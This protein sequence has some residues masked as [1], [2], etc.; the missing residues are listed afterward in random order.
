LG[1]VDRIQR[2]GP[3][4]AGT[5]NVTKSTQDSQY[6][7][8]RRVCG[9]RLVA[10]LIAV[11]AAGGCDRSESP[12]PRVVPIPKNIETLR[13]ELVELIQKHA[14]KV[15]SGMDDAIAIATLGLVYEANGLW[16]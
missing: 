10:L 15:R 1:E 8:G 2:Q 4:E 6:K 7:K 16:G 11:S 3:C 14:E 12:A 9:G 5:T 13:P